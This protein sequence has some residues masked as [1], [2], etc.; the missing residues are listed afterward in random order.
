MVTLTSLIAVQCRDG[1]IPIALSRPSY[2]RRRPGRKQEAKMLVIWLGALLVIVGILFMANRAIWRGRLS[3]QRASPSAPVTTLEPP[4]RGTRFL[5][6][7][8]NWPGIV[9][10]VL[11]GALLLIGGLI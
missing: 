7:D 9:M 2:I 6:F 10:L 4:Q 11:G 1:T 3:G 8:S 5:G